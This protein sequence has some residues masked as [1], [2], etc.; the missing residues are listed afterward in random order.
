MEG[1]TINQVHSTKFV[2]III[3]DE[4]PWKSRVKQVS[5]KVTKGM[6]IIIKAKPYI[7]KTT[8]M[9]LYYAFVFPYITY[10]NIVWGSTF[11]THLD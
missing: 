9:D 7:N 5:I 1:N 2:G 10:C 8:L 6:G 11:N 3:D 4:L